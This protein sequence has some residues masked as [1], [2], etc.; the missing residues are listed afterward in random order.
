MAIYTR[1]AFALGVLLAGI[2]APVVVAADENGEPWIEFDGKPQ[3]NPKG[4]GGGKVKGTGFLR[5]PSG[6][7]VDEV[8]IRWQK[9]RAANK[10]LWST[11]KA[12]VDESKTPPTWSFTAERLEAGEYWF[13]AVVTFITPDGE[14]KVFDSLDRRRVAVKPVAE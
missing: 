5:P 8:E 13:E 9:Y 11:I 7:K 3:H 2:A 12:E 14:K 1:R 6:Y 4:I 10:N